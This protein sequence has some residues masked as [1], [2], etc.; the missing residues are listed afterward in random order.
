METG[1]E[2]LL[3]VTVIGGYLGAGKTTLVNHLLRNA[4]GLRL[5]VL[6]NEFGELPIDADLIESQD[7][8]VIS[9]AGG[10]VCCSYGNDLML[11]MIDLAQMKPKPEHVLLEAS[12]VALPGAIASS[13]GLLPR[14]RLDGVVVLADAETVQVRADDIYM[15]DTV[16]QQLHAADLI[17][18]NKTDLVEQ[19]ALAS[20][21]EWLVGKTDRGEIIE[22]RQAA[23]PIDVV[24]GQKGSEHNQASNEK[25]DHGQL[26]ETASFRLDQP[27]DPEKL[28]RGLVSAKLGIIRAKGFARSQDGTVWEIQIVGRRWTV[29]PSQTAPAS[30]IVCIGTRAQFQPDLVADF[31][32]RVSNP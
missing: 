1:S 13:V 31:I 22:A 12:G 7:D 10:C 14:Y 30:G 21:R 11:A 15:S 2:P 24:L 8:N 17:V 27:I 32:A 20:T 4:G 3:P 19:E 26:F 16:L 28:A 6:V 5:A 23:L 9:I 25:L 29:E 18:L